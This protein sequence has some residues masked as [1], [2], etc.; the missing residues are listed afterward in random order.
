MTLG[1][2]EAAILCLTCGAGWLTLA[3]EGYANARGWPV[4]A[5]LADG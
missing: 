1:L 4:G 3:Y 5:W 2:V